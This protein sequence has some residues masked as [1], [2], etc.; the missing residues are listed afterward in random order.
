[1][2]AVWPLVVRRVF[3]LY[4]SFA[5]GGAVVAGCI[6]SIVTAFIK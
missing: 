3:M 4:F 1:M 2:A 6:Y 5:L